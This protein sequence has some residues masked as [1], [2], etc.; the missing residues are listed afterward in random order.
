M[1]STDT[2]MHSYARSNP[3]WMGFLALLLTVLPTACVDPGAD[4]PSFCTD[5][6]DGDGLYDCFEDY[7]GTDPFDV[8]TDLDGYEDGYEWNNFSDPLDMLDYDYL[9]GWDHFPYPADLQGEGVEFG[10]VHHQIQAE[11]A[12]HQFVSLY[13]F[14]GNVIHIVSWS[15]S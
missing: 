4:E 10:Q 1:L 14:Y 3:I 2:A 8:D 12:N 13:S 9:G 7:L 6:S 15:H 11:D 5:D